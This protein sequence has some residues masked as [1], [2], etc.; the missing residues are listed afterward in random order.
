MYLDGN[1]YTAAKK[2]G[3]ETKESQPSSFFVW[4]SE[5]ES[6]RENNF[7]AIP[8]QTRGKKDLGEMCDVTM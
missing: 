1:R 7:L 6:Q 5:K 4:K 3:N 8:K 2:L